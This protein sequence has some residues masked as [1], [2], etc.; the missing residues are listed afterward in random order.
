MEPTKRA[1]SDSVQTPNEVLHRRIAKSV[2]GGDASD[3]QQ[4]LFHHIEQ[5]LVGM[6][7]GQRGPSASKTRV[8]YK[9]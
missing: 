4:L 1:L 8:L 6:V 3:E 5:D 7:L 9:D 2:A